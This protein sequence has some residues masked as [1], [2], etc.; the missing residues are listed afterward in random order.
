MKKNITSVIVALSALL[1]SSVN[2][3]TDTVRIKETTKE[4]TIIHDTV[5]Q[6]QPVVIQNPT[7]VQNEEP[8]EKRPDLRRGEFGIRYMPT[9]SSLA[10]RT[11]N[12]DVIDGELTMSHGYGV[13]FGLNFS[14]NIG[15]Q[16]EVNYNET[17]QK[18]KDRGLERQVS[19]SYLNIPVLLS[20]NTDKTMPVNLNIVAGPQFGLNVG[21]SIKTTGTATGD[22]LKA[23]VGVKEGDVGFA[24]GAGLEFALNRAHTL[25]LDLG[26]RG[27]YGF[28]DM[29]ASNTS[30][31]PDTYNILVKASR[32]TYAGY[33]GLTWCF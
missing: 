9:F 16:A 24:Y 4:T 26:F 21:S 32:K 5:Q 33:L 7:P 10:L 22:T 12:G 25:R 14:K 3:Q 8:E 23:V 19:V 18:Y 15:I 28:V 13:M 6:P 31:N 27:F 20:L 17:S 30:N 11:Y 2:A 29:S 1:F